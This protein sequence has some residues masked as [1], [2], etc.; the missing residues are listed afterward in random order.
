M[1]RSPRDIRGVMTRGLEAF[2]DRSV[3]MVRAF[4]PMLDRALLICGF[5]AVAVAIVSRALVARLVSDAVGPPGIALISAAFGV[6][7]A[8][9]S[10]PAG[11]RQAFEAYSWLG[12]TEVE[13]FK[14]RT[15]GPVPTKPAE[16][17]VWLASTP[18]TPAM[19]LGRIEVLAFVGRFDEASAE[20]DLVEP[21][22][23]E[24]RFEAESLRQYIDWLANGSVDHSALAMAVDRLPQGSVARR[25]GDVN[26]AL[27]DARV[28]YMAG[29]PSWS[30]GLRAVRAPLG[31]E[32]SMVTLRDTWFRY[33]AVAFTVALV[34]TVVLSLLR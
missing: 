14:A 25:M 23:P 15:G 10:V 8:Y 13:R 20:L 32:P 9:L 26:V 11:L 24:E 7:V 18:S 22:T 16:I 5:V 21:V 33:G 3:A 30:D 12:R 1:T 28:R 27:A 17:E 31:R 34:V 2:P 19:R 4:A 29:D 6:V